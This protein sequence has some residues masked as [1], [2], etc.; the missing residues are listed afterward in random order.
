M[1]SAYGFHLT[2]GQGTIFS[3]NAVAKRARCQAFGSWEA[4]LREGVPYICIRGPVLDLNRPLTEVLKAAHEIAQVML[5]IVAVEERNSLLI[6]EPHNNVTWRTGPHGL[7]TQLTLAITFS[8]QLGNPKVIVR[9]AN[10]EVIPDPPY[11]PPQYHPAYRYFRYSQAAQNVF[12]SYRNMFLALEAILD[13]LAPKLATETETDWLK[14]ALADAVKLKGLNLNEFAK[15]TS[16]TPMENFLGAHY[17]TVRCA[18]FHSKSSAGQTLRPGSLADQDDVLHQL[19][20]VQALVE[21]LLKAEYSVRLPQSGFF[22]SGFGHLLSQIDQVTGL[23]IS[24]A[25]C[26]TVEQVLANEKSPDCTIAPVCFRGA[27]RGLTDEWLFVS[28]INPKTFSFEKINSLRLIAAPNNHLFLSSIAKK[29]NET[30]I[31]VEL[32]VTEM[33]KLVVNI[34]CVLRNLQQPRRGFLS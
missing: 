26:P 19:L 25:D 2:A 15:P 20:A 1:A 31:K 5:D 8:A 30:L 6:V 14:R 29:M 21:H 17:S 13:H 32:E 16:T 4:E 9:N 24:A 27:N 22:H 28:E 3:L 10:G 18:I 23:L 11:V 34:R 12:D 7:K 33:A